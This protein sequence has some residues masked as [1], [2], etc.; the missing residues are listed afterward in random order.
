MGCG[1]KGGGN[2]AKAT[3]RKYRVSHNGAKKDFAT[4]A[5]AEKYRT[6]NNIAAPVRPVSVAATA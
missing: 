6:D 4:Q 2:V 5:E 3:V 1:C